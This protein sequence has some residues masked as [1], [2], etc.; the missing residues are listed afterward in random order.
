MA[1][2]QYM[3]NTKNY[4]RDTSRIS[5]TTNPVEYEVPNSGAPRRNLSKIKNK[6]KGYLK[7]IMQYAIERSLNTNSQ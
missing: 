7:K 6:I 4:D 3:D 2:G 5:T 1:Y